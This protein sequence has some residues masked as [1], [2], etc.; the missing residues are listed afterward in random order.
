MVDQ[1]ISDFIVSHMDDIS[2][3]DPNLKKD[4]LSVLEIGSGQGFLTKD[5]IKH[6][7][8]KTLTTIEKDSN[9]AYLLKNNYTDSTE[10]K[11]KVIKIIEGDALDFDFVSE[12]SK[13]NGNVWV[14]S[15]LPYN[16]GSL[17][18]IRI[19]ENINLFSNIIIMLQK[20]VVDRIVAKSCTREY[21]KL[22]VLSQSCCHVR[23]LKVIPKNA[24]NPQPKI[25]SALVHLRRKESF[26]DRD[27]FLQLKEVCKISFASKRKTFFNNIKLS[28][29][30]DILDLIKGIVDDNVRAEE[31][32]ADKM[33][34][35]AS[36]I[37]KQKML[38]NKDSV[39]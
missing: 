3:Y 19:L 33:L 2:K 11:D 15:N 9:L 20:E 29:R 17:I 35:I 25:K 30:D 24:F 31:I 14:I 38:T 8:V 18:L 12:F 28:K 16:V 37:Y 22:S 26:P 39:A 6:K 10:Y 1:S 27:I 23:R 7:N 5:I 13:C 32:S 21:G 4:E 36:K 34:E